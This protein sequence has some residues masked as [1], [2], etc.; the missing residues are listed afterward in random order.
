MR[1]VS[2]STPACRIG[3]VRLSERR[4]ILRDAAGADGNVGLR[5]KRAGGVRAKSRTRRS[6]AHPGRAK[7]KG[8]SSGRWLNT[9]RPPGTHGRV[10]AQ[11]PRPVGP[12]LRFGGG[13][14]DGTNGTWVNPARKRADTFRKEKAP[15]GESQER[16][17]GERNSARA[18]RAQAAERVIKP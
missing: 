12:A 6:L 15:Q 8:A 3:E 18:R 14:T 17:R 11:E 7:P 5:E 2:L 4:L 13:S 10:K 9:V 16:C 1:V